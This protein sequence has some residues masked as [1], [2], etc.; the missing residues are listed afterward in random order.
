MQLLTK[1]DTQ[2]QANRGALSAALSFTGSHPLQVIL[3]SI[4]LLAPCH[5][6]QHLEACDL[7]SHTYNAWLA[8]LV[9][10]GQAPGLWLQRRWS[11][12]LFD[13][14]LSGL[15]QLVGLRIAERLAVSAAVLVFFWGN[16]A[17][18]A[19]AAQRVPWSVARCIA[20][21]THG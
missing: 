20:M 11:N 1:D 14:A 2:S 6:H 10:Q 13:Y 5:W 16:F 18:V 7:A 9:R 19:A 3:V 8:S 17:L 4:V 15:S 12:V 21:I